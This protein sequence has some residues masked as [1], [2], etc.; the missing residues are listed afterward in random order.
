MRL[1]RRRARAEPRD[2]SR[3]RRRWM[4]RSRATRSRP[5]TTT[6]GELARCAARGAPAAAARVRAGARPARARGIPARGPPGIHKADPAE[7]RELH[8]P[9]RLRTT[10]LALG[11]AA[12]IFIVATA[13]PDHRVCSAAGAR[14]RRRPR[15]AA[16]ELETRSSQAPG[17]AAAAAGATATQ[18]AAGAAPRSSPAPAGAS[19][20]RR[21]AARSSAPPSSRLS[22]PRDRIEDVADGVIRVTDRHGGFVLSSSV[23]AGEGPTPARRSTCAS[24]ATGSQ[25]AVADLSELAH[26]RSRTQAARDVTAEFTSPRRRLADA[27]AER[28]GLLRQLARADT[29]NETAAI[30]A[31]LRAVN[32]RIDRAQARAAQAARARRVRGGERRGRARRAAQDGD[33]GWSLGDAARDARVRAGR[34]RRRGDRRACRRGAG[35]DRSP[36]SCGSPTARSSGAA[37]SRRSMR[38]PRRSPRP[39][40]EKRAAPVVR[41][42]CGSLAA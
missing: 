19:L 30:R 34:R 33:G 17:A 10:P 25:A 35:G 42:R 7:R 3:A 18:A 32:R 37:G 4:P 1:R 13:R 21:A 2:D 36:C 8:T 39:A 11:T 28:R 31:R 12:S 38:R 22:T 6:C 14:P 27:L 41:C 29:P 24:P 40:I 9:R 23:S 15:R 5:S 16:R 26:V 20:P